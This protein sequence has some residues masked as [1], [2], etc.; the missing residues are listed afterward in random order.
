MGN[1]ATYG[2][3]NNISFAEQHFPLLTQSEEIRKGTFCDDRNLPDNCHGKEYCFCTHR[4]KVKLNSIVQITLLG[5]ENGNFMNHPI[6]LHGS[7]FYITGIGSDATKISYEP[8]SE[9][10]PY[11]DTL[12]VPGSGYAIIRFKADNPGFWFFHCHYDYHHAAGMSAVFQVGE[13]E[14]MNKGPKD[15][16][17]CGNY[18]PDIEYV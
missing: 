13:L 3:F 1:V 8:Q 15:F 16:P 5:T 2:A 18:L 9:N 10:P 6:H 7:H 4:L 14:E 17:K 12:S 11:K